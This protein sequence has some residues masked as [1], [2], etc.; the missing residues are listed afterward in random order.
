M[1]DIKVR[2]PKTW[3]VCKNKK[4]YEDLLL[5]GECQVFKNDH[6]KIDDC[7]RC[8]NGQSICNEC[9]DE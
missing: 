2:K 8:G 3:R 6:L 7:R 9:W 1:Q 4:H 5:Y